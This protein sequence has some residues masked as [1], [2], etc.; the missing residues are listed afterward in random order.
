MEAKEE[1]QTMQELQT[2]PPLSQSQ[3][4]K[5]NSKKKISGELQR[6]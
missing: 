3:M 4:G 1:E 6:K 5:K 2:I